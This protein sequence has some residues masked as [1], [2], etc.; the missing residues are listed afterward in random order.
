MKTRNGIDGGFTPTGGWQLMRERRAAARAR[1][2]QGA[3]Q[4]A[5]GHAAARL[6]TRASRNY[7]NIND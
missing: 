3:S 4:F 5:A 7:L 2:V 1:S 6:V